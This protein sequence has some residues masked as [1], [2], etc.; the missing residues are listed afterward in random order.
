MATT[1]TRGRDSFQGGARLGSALGGSTSHFEYRHAHIEIYTLGAKAHQAKAGNADSSSLRLGVYYRRHQGRSTT[2]SSSA[3]GWH[4]QGVRQRRVEVAT[5]SRDVGQHQEDASSSRTSS[6][7]AN[8]IGISK[9]VDYEK[10]SIQDSPHGEAKA[11]CEKMGASIKSSVC[12]HKAKGVQ[13]VRAKFAERGHRHRAAEGRRDVPGWLARQ[14]TRGSHARSKRSCTQGRG[15]MSPFKFKTSRAGH[16]AALAKHAQRG[17]RQ[18]EGAHKFTPTET[19]RSVNTY[20]S[21]DVSVNFG[22]LYSRSLQRKDVAAGAKGVPRKCVTNGHANSRGPDR[23]DKCGAARH[24]VARDGA[25]KVH[26]RRALQGANNIFPT[27]TS[28]KSQMKLLRLPIWTTPRSTR[29]TFRGVD[30]V[31]RAEWA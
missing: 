31:E 25:V 7:S 18:C 9:V 23:C 16:L 4:V 10:A 29:R 27:T 21:K 2:S 8:H 28:F 30:S 11:R 12:K 14:R 15:S 19:M 22:S 20:P 1:C 13:G 26:A 24:R 6:S 17:V 3:D 5:P